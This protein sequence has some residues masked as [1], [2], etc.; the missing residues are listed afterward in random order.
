MSVSLL[1]SVLLA[2][3]GQGVPGTYHLSPSGSD[4]GDGSAARP[5]LTLA[6]AAARIPDNGSTV[7][8]LDGTYTGLQSI[9]R[10]FKVPAVFRAAR[11]YRAVL[12]NPAGHRVLRIYDAS[13]VVLDGIEFEGVPSRGEFL[14]H[15]GTA[16][17]RNITFQNCILHDSYDNDIVKINDRA[18]FITFRGCLFYNQNQHPGDE[19]LDINTVTDVTLEDNLF[20]NDFGGSGRTNANNTHPFV[21]IK[22]SGR[23]P[24]SRRFRIRRNVFLNWEGLR[25]QPFLLIGE[26]GQPF[27]EAEEVMVENNLFLGNSANDIGS[28][29]GVK[30]ARDVTF[31]SNTVS[32]DLPGRGGCYA[33]R[34]NREGRNPLN[35][36]ISFFNN[37]WSDPTGTMNDF[38]DGPPEDSVRVV[39]R[40]NLY[41]NGG[42]PVPRDR[43]AVNPADDPGAVVADPGLADPR[44]LALPRRDP[45]TGLFLSGSATIRQEFE[46]MVLR[47]AALPRGSPAA[48]AA[49]PAQAPADDILGRP[50]PAGVRPDLGAF[51]LGAR[52]AAK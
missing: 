50:R 3:G 15:V 20:F 9:S 40:R 4:G 31:R 25:D 7:L 37:I 26:D 35:E 38:A 24:V 44:G 34:I 45:G 1:A 52:P 12:R 51:E 8:L 19:H 41:W 43:A 27:P 14:V 17:A 39:L 48:D 32:G 23:E 10:H 16:N 47:Y 18:S 22:N 5:W 21:L 49:D 46:R 13:N 2:A 36:G 33:V 6:H 42:K 30:G 28:A 29:F 11:P